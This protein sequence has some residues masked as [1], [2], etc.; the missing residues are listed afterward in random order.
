MSRNV[1]T[2]SSPAAIFVG[3]AKIYTKV[4][5]KGQTALVGGQKISK[6]NMR[7]ESYG[8]VDELNSVLGVCRAVL[9]EAACVA[10]GSQNGPGSDG[11][12]KLSAEIE[13]LQHWLF[14]LGSL[15]AC[16]EEDRA[17]YKLPPISPDHVKWLEERIDG[18]TA[19]LK[20]LKNFILPSGSKPSAQLHV[21]RTVARRAERCIVRMG[22]DI[23]E[24]AIPFMNRVSDYL[25]VMARY[26]NHLLGVADVPWQQSRA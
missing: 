4:G 6:D 12:M 15:L 5:D 16:I 23:P 9:G 18:A 20:P 26:S 10:A 21:A 8:T 14:D 3:M 24:Q 25:F 13:K 11:L 2:S 1:M 7:L 19:V 17:K 22:S